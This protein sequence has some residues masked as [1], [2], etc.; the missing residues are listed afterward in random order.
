MWATRGKKGE[1]GGGELGEGAGEGGTVPSS[2]AS[3]SAELN[4]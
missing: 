3:S 1:S 2:K 4:K